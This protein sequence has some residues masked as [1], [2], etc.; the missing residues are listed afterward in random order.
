MIRVVLGEDSFLA[1]EGITRVLESIED[2]DLVA[3]CGDLD[4]LRS[5]VD[6]VRPDVVLTDI[7]MPPTNTDEGIRFAGEL[8]HSLPEVGVVVLSQHAEPAYAMSLFENGSSQRAY[9]LK[10]RVKDKDELERALREV[11]DGR[12]L[13]DPRIVDKLVS[14]RLERSGDR[15][16]HLARARDP[17]ADRRRS[18]QHLDRRVAADH[19]A[20][21]R[22]PHQRDLR[23]ARAARGRRRQPARQGHPALPDGRRG[24]MSEV[25]YR[26][27]VDRPWLERLPHSSRPLRGRRARPRGALL[28]RRQ[29][30]LPAGVL[31]PG[32]GDRLA[33]GGRRDRLPLPRRHRLLAG[34][35]D[36][37]PARQRLLGAAARLG[38]RAD[39]RERA[40]GGDRDA[41]AAAPRPARVAARQRSRAS[42][43]S[44]SRSRQARPSARRSARPR[45]SP[46]A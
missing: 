30:R 22:A 20:R 28:R 24:L 6:E 18:Q 9:L 34:R 21:R 27:S 38:A 8:R 36:R 31:R 43:R 19:Q 5:T 39:L 3:A 42:A 35:A 14:A 12:S 29:D 15:E 45:C 13:V 2:V 26:E 17:R 1:R 33:A 46:G 41:A 7:R 4:E 16:A 40:R 11:A 25:A 44:R 32:G 37:R 10:E 23:Q